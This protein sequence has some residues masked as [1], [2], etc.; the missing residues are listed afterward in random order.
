MVLFNSMYV[1]LICQMLDSVL[2]YNA[3]T[4]CICRIK[5]NQVIW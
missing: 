2:A 4:V 5:K 1:S 3:N